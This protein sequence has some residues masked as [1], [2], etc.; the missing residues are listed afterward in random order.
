MLTVHVKYHWGYSLKFPGVSKSQPTLIVPPPTTLLG[1]LTCSLSRI[2]KWPE[3]SISGKK[4]L[5]GT[6]RAAEFIRC[7]AFG[8]QMFRETNG[9]AGITFTDPIRGIILLFQRKE[10]RR[11][12]RY[13]FGLIPMGKVYAP[14]FSAKIIYIIDSAKANKILGVDWQKEILPSAWGICAIGNWQSIT[15]VMKVS[16]KKANLSSEKEVNT[17]IYFPE[18][19]VSKVSGN[20]FTTTFWKVGA[21]WEYGKMIDLSKETTSFIVPG[22]KVPYVGGEVKVTL[23][24]TGIA[25]TDG[26]STLVTQK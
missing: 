14:N 25:L 24:P 2:K 10:R 15:T 19:A 13:R 8:G 16:L 20:Y 3:T 23:S 26:D 7:A 21:G 11:I 5:S 6:T 1:A 17:D 9:A 22:N 4:I 12:E 18:K